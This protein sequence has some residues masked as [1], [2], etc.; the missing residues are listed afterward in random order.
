MCR[1]SLLLATLACAAAFGQNQPEAKTQRLMNVARLWVTAEYFHPYLASRNIAWSAALADAYP[2]IRDAQKAAEYAAA[3]NR[4]LSALGDKQTFAAPD[5]NTL[6]GSPEIS[7]WQQFRFHHGLAPA[8]GSPSP[9]YSALLVRA[10]RKVTTIPID[11][12]EEITAHVRLS[13]PAAATAARIS[14]S[15]ELEKNEYPS[16]AWRYAG[17]VR[18]WGAVRYFFAYKDVMGE[19]WDH[20]FVDYLPKILA[21]KNAREYHLEIAELVSH[22]SDSNA[23]AE[24]AVLDRYWGEARLPL[25]VRLI[26]KKPVIVGLSEQARNAGLKIGDIVSLLDGENIADRIKQRANYLSASNR[27]GLSELVARTL[28][29][30]PAG[31]TA[32]LGVTTGAGDSK[33]VALKRTGGTEAPSDGEPVRVLPNAIGYVDVSRLEPDGAGPALDKLAGTKAIVFDLRGECQIDPNAIAA[34]LTGDPR[35]A[36]LIT[37]PIA[38]A[39]DLAQPEIESATGSYFLIKR[40]APAGGTPYSG[41]VVVLIDARTRGRAEQVA[42]YIAAATK[43]Q[44]FGTPSAGSPSQ[45]TSV[46]LPGG[47]LVRFSGEDIRLTNGGAVQRE[48]LQPTENVPQTLAGVRAG[49][50]EVLE[51]ALHALR[52]EAASM[53]E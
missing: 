31:S 12:G 39:P 6:P 38:E 35:Q 41:R 42:L 18:L 27:A 13:E 20:V 50:D 45:T 10:Q 52:D 19:D 7:G 33:Q 25:S 11:V 49:K 17:A 53:V 44:I 32:T 14:G 43:V 4:M 8:D 9:F 21:A 29:N 15:E 47:I 34:R 28:L 24:S 5:A 3:V 16:E 23:A 51:Q 36:L 40:V 37:G 48:G 30:G 46:R 2:A 1:V 26:E 22:L